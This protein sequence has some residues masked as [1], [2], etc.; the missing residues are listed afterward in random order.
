MSG[1]VELKDMLNIQPQKNMSDKIFEQIS[2]LI[3]SG[4]LPEG[5]AFPNETVLCEQF[6][7]GRSTIRKGTVVNGIT[8]ILGSMPLKEAVKESSEQD[9]REFRLMLESCTASLAAQRISEEEFEE[10]Q[11][12]QDAYLEAYQHMQ[13]DSM[14]E[15]DKKFHEKIAAVTHNFLLVTTMAAVSEIWNKEIRQN[16]ENAIRKDIGKL[17]IS[18]ESHR[19]I[20]DAIHVHDSKEA[21]KRM[22]EHIIKIS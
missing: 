15:L 19:E 9:F 5:Y 2:Q 22:M 17:K 20:L 7:I 12:I 1:M 11:Q 13:Y 8:T 10:L 16:F 14:T 21:Q 4:G 6:Q 3:R 18:I